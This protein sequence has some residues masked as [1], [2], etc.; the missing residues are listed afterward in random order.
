MDPSKKTGLGSSAALIVSFIAGTFK[1]LGLLDALQKDEALDLVHKHSQV[2]N[3]FVQEKVGSGFDIACSVY[4]SQSYQRF[5]NVDNLTK[6]VNKIQEGFKD[7]AKVFE[8][9]GSVY[10]EFSR[11]FDY[12][13]KKQ[14]INSQQYQVCL[15]DVNSGSDTKLMVK[16]VLDWAKKHQQ[17]EGD[18]FSNELCN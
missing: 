13:V 18:L 2:L 1:A 5:T 15:I 17:K 8:D 3:A 16:L 12:K 7:Q 9:L 6:L 4:G 11:T 14:I 10:E